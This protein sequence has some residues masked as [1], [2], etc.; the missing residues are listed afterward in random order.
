MVRIIGL[1]GGIASGKSTV[2]S[3]LRGLG[4]II[5]DADELARKIVEQDRPALAE[6]ERVFG[7]EV[8]FEDG[9]LNRKKLG[10]IV[11]NNQSLLKKLNEITHPYIIK[12]IID[13]I[14]W[15]KK[16]STNRVIILDAALLIEMDLIYLVEEVW[17]VSVPK[18][19]Q[20]NRL[21]QRE[22]I[23]ADDAE[24]R[25]DAQMPLDEKKQ[26]AHIIIDN[27]KDVDYLKE[28]VEQNWSRL[29]E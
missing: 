25:I 1:T 19:V 27:S 20:I 22:N 7:K 2:S 9:N 26:Y 4:A 10:T 28:Q 16:T 6:I 5:I 13:V 14:N 21:I 15:Y 12:E 23:S 17:L 29:I 8:I 11:F 24:K 3:I 18:E